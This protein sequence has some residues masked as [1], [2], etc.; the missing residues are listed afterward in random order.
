LAKRPR[1]ALDPKTVAPRARRE[2]GW[3][4]LRAGIP[5][6]APRLGLVATSPRGWASAEP[7][8]ST[9]MFESPGRETTRHRD[10]RGRDATVRKI[11]TDSSNPACSASLASR[12]V[13]F[14]PPIGGRNPAERGHSWQ[15]V[16]TMGTGLRT[17]FGPFSVSRGPLSP[18]QPNHPRLGTD[19]SR[20]SINALADTRTGL[21]LKGAP[22]GAVNRGRTIWFGT[23]A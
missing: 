16:R 1:D 12:D 22:S 10:P 17:H 21:G 5:Y 23:I 6:P 14:P 20:S 18:T 11:D 2:C 8:S 4:Q 15:I 7:G 3:T 9:G 19:V 13:L